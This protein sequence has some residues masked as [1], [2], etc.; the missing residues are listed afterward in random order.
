W[1]LALDVEVLLSD[2]EGLPL[3]LIEARALG[4]PIV[5][6]D[7]GGVA[8][9][10]RDGV[11]GR[12]VRARDAGAASRAI[13]E[14]LAMLDREALDRDARRVLGAVDP[15]GLAPDEHASRLVRAYERILSL[16]PIG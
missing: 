6:T 9:L 14:T 2:Q 10:V 13:L 3:S 5:A 11:D 16:P 7:V 1:H 8:D 15:I 12:I 4:V